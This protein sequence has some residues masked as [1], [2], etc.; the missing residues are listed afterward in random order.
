MAGRHQVL[1]WRHN[2][3]NNVI[4]QERRISPFLPS[5]N[6]KFISTSERSG[7]PSS[8]RRR[9]LASSDK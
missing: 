9:H 8:A 4:D 6:R 7:Q 2:G 1:H 5:V 3:R